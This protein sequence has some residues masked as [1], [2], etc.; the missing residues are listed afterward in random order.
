MEISSYQDHDAP[1][2]IHQQQST[3]NNNP[4]SSSYTLTHLKVDSCPLPPC[5]VST[6]KGHT[7][8]FPANNNSSSMR[9]L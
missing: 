9:G 4:S 2:T 8:Y 3:V 7:P 5:L 1:P 6:T